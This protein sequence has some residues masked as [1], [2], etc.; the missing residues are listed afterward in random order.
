MNPEKF[1]LAPPIKKSGLDNSPK[2]CYNKGGLFF[3]F[4]LFFVNFFTLF[5]RFFRYSPKKYKILGEKTN[6]LGEKIGFSNEFFGIFFGFLRFFRP[7]FLYALFKMSRPPAGHA[8]GVPIGSA[9]WI[10]LQSQCGTY[11]RGNFPIFLS[12]ADPVPKSVSFLGQPPG[13]IAFKKLGIDN[14]QKIWYNI[15]RKEGE[16]KLRWYQLS[17]T[18]RV[19]FACA[20]C[21]PDQ[22]IGP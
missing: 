6:N 22:P 18:R 10:F 11:A 16:E 17:K 19:V 20:F 15:I 21:A 12:L 5:S 3:F 4:F 1:H 13:K 7:D 9:L 14:R 2:I 8:A